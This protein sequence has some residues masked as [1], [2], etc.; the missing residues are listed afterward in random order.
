VKLEPASNLAQRAGRRPVNAAIASLGGTRAWCQHE[1]L[2][3]L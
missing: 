2:L 3:A 1:M